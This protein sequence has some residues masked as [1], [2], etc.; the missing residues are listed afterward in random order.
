MINQPREASSVL[1]LLPVSCINSLLLLGT[2]G[3]TRPVANLGTCRMGPR[4]LVPRRKE[5]LPL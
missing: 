5:I 3:N 1:N 4:S 2:Q